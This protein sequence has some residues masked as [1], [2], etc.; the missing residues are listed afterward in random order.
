MTLVDMQLLR[1]LFLIC[2]A[3]LASACAQGAEAD[4][5]A[6]NVE[7]Q[8]VED[9]AG[10]DCFDP[11]FGSDVGLALCPEGEIVVE[12]NVASSSSLVVC[13]CKCTSHDNTGWIVWT[14]EASAKQ[15]VV[16]IYPGKLVSPDT[17]SAS[18]SPVI[19][20]QLWHVEMCV[21]VDRA[22]LDQSDFITLVKRLTNSDDS[23]YCFD[24]LYIT[25][26][27]TTV[28][29]KLADRWIHADDEQYLGEDVSSEDLAD[30]RH[31]FAGSAESP[32]K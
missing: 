14:D 25:I 21:S 28:K 10:S 5:A 22:Q 32:F 15:S 17:F 27:G 11:G 1:S 29:L 31:L 6:L 4:P 20:D 19:R 7:T 18:T 2:W 12:S 24:P 26:Q 23:P 16:P 3:S 30:L 8:A 13:D 9:C